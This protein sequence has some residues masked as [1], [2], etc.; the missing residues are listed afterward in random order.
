MGDVINFLTAAGLDVIHIDEKG[1]HKFEGKPA[2]VTK[3]VTGLAAAAKNKMGT[4]AEFMACLNAL[5]ENI[6]NDYILWTKRC[7][8]KRGGELTETNKKMITEF[9]DELGYEVGKKYVKVT[10][11]NGG[12]VWGFVVAVTN[13]P[14][15]KRGDI[16]KA[17]GFNAP[18][19]NAARGNIVEGGYHINWTGPDYL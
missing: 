16:L 1:A 14:K 5:I 8:D 2:P 10:T 11:K 9:C 15:F 17:A 12:A 18:A 6:K 7:A 3:K 4:D 19:R 13:D